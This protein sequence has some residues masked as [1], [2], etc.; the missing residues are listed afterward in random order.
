[1]DPR[2]VSDYAGLAAE[3]LAAL[4]RLAADQRTLGDVLDW[5]RAHHLPPRWPEVVTQDEYTHDV[6][7][8]YRDTLHLV[9]DTT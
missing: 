6:I 7:V 8:P 9:Y 5:C 1:M 4:R 3:D 2:E